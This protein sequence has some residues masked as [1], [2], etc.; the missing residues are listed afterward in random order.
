MMGQQSKTDFGLHEVLSFVKEVSP[1]NHRSNRGPFLSIFEGEHTI[2]GNEIVIEVALPKRFPTEKPMFFLK[3]PKVIGFLPHIEKD[4]FICYSHDEGLLLDQSNPS[5]IV[6][7]AF[8][9]ADKTLR[10]G[11]SG[12]NYGDYLK[13][14]E[15]LWS[16]QD[17]LKK[18]DSLFSPGD[19]FEKIRIFFD[20]KRNK[21][22]IVNTKDEK[23][24]QILKTLYKCDVEREF[25]SYQGIHIPLRKNSQVKPPSYW[26]FWNLKY[27]R[28]II[29][30]HIN[31][32]TKQRLRS[33]LKN[34]KIN[35]Q[36]KEYIL[37][38]IPIENDQR[39][40]FGIL[41]EN[42]QKSKQVKSNYPFRHP[43]KKIQCSFSMVPLSVKRHN[44]E[45]LLNR[46]QG[47]NQ[48]IGKKVTLV[49]LGSLGSRI[50]F[51]LA[52]AGITSFMLI[53]KD[54]LDIDNI[55]RHELG[56]DSLYWRLEDRYVGITKAEAMKLR[57][58]KQFPSLV[59][60]YEAADVLDLIEEEKKKILESDMVILALGAPTVEQTL[61]KIFHSI[62]D[63]P[64]I[65][66]TWIEP[67]GLGGHALLTNNKSKKGC[68]HCLFTDIENSSILI[69]NR[70]S[71]VAPD[72]VFLK[73]LAGCDSVFTPYGS[74][75]ALQT[76]ILASR[77]AIK[78]LQEKE[79]ENPLLSWK[80]EADEVLSQ[81]K[82]VSER[83]ALTSEQLFNY[84]YL[85]K[86]ENCPICGKG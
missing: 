21:T 60:D 33:Y 23:T 19:T 49:G 36:H 74:L 14:F 5:G 76:A 51:E 79:K 55:Y 17:M 46:T 42:F 65:M 39:I 12:L 70:A 78:A 84:R 53:D 20:E 4:G 2:N 77:L 85:Y 54:I 31:S 82:R 13:E 80:G 56:S 24:T 15:V 7:E 58:Q 27:L 47:Q 40:F 61:N 32:S 41:L 37:I 73:T 86:T 34:S 59:V 11:I 57:L 67:L 72:Q 35:S 1:L 45:F 43:L 44:Q 48:L 71:F 66:Y 68:F 83:Y 38:S 16:R 62:K 10:D 30:N 26:E 64:P 75:E 69:P 63:S 25:I 28:K 3:N 50:A 29:F 9:R 18:V 81:G 22:V 52:R 8:R 6:K